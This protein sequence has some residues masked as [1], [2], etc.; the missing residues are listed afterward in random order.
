MNRLAGRNRIQVNKLAFA[1]AS[2]NMKNPM[3]YPSPRLIGNPGKVRS[4]NTKGSTNAKNTI[5]ATPAA[6]KLGHKIA[7]TRCD[8]GRGG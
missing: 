7:P 5:V 3:L 4:R 8:N 6:K 2:Q 1:V